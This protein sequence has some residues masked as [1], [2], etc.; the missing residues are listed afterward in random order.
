MPKVVQAFTYFIPARYFITILRGIYLK[1]IGIADL[2]FESLCLTLFT[3]LAVGA[4][5]E[6]CGYDVSSAA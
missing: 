1:S 5:I 6:D 3:F 2:W 4:A